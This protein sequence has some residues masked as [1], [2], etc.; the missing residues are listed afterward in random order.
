MSNRD[1]NP[2]VV[3][4]LHVLLRYLFW[5]PLRAMWGPCRSCAEAHELLLRVSFSHQTWNPSA[6]HC[7][8][9]AS[10]QLVTQQVLIPPVVTAYVPQ[11]PEERRLRLAAVRYQGSLAQL[12]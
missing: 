12:D 3:H 10:P 11:Q 6:L 4:G 2:G 9:A 1:T 7:R 5:D 8:I